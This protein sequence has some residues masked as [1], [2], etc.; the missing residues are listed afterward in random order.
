MKRRVRLALLPG[1]TLEDPTY[2]RALGSLA[3]ALRRSGWRAR[4]FCPRRGR[5]GELAHFRPDLVHLHFSGHLG[6]AARRWLD[7]APTRKAGLVVT[8]QDLDHP[9]LPAPDGAQRRQVARLL[10]RAGAVT[11]LTPD[12][13]GAVG[14]RYRRAAGKVAVVGN[15]VGREWFSRAPAPRDGNSIVAAS[16]LAPY[17][18]IDLL[19]WAFCGFR[20]R[21]PEARLTVFGDDFQGGRFQGLARRLGLAGKVRFSRAASAGP[22]R[23]ALAAARFFVSASRRETYGMAVLEAMAGGAPVLATRTGVAARQLRHGRDAWLVPPGDPGALERGLLRLWSDARLRRRLSAAGRRAALRALWERR[24]R[25]YGR[26][27]SAAM[28]RPCS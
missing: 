24:A 25:D 17:K 3:A 13:A 9:D 10:A 23:R 16:R 22:L 21:T 7:S 5:L 20:A 15:G 27:Y 1:T 11:A 6:E 19:L 2:R 26:L 14:R 18:G 4:C 8:F 12:L 28:G